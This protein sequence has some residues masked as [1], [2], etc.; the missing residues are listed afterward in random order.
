MH[1]A[2]SLWASVMKG[3]YIYFNVSPQLEK[4]MDISAV[5]FRPMSQNRERSF[6]LFSSHLGFAAA[7]MI[8]SVVYTG[9]TSSLREIAVTD[10]VDIDSQVEFRIY[11]DNPNRYESAGLTG[12]GN[13]L[14]V[15][16]I[17][18]D[19]PITAQS[20]QIESVV[21]YPN[22]AQDYVSIITS[23][24][25]FEV[26]IVDA[27][28]KVVVQKTNKNKIDISDLSRGTYFLRFTEGEI[29]RQEIIV[30]E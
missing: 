20:G 10:H 15:I 12:V 29:F 23:R 9:V 6:A 2:R 1:G 18:E 14:E 24:T 22:P 11:G 4:R 17:V 21:I 7:D 27:S 30:V 13:D 19:N 28:G 5:N 3:D 16:G 25:G 8:E 26:Q